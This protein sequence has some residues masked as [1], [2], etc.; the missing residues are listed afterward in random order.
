MNQIQLENEL[1]LLEIEPEHG[2]LVRLRDKMGNLELITEPRLAENFRLLLPVPGMHANYILGTEQELTSAE[3]T[4]QGIRL[5]W[6]GPL[7]NERG[8]FDLDVTIWIE[9]ID[10]EVRVRCEVQNHTKHPIAEVWYGL[11]GGMTGL[12]SAGQAK[13]TK[14]LLPSSA[15]QWTAE[16]FREFGIG[17]P[18]NPGL[19]LHG[20]EYTWWY[21][22]QMP[23]PWVSFYH[24]ELNRGVYFANH[25]REIRSKIFRMA[26]S[27]GTAERRADGDWPRP[28]E[29]NGEPLGVTMNWTHFPYTK[30]GETFVGPTLVLRCHDGGWQ[31]SAAIYRQ[32]FDQTWGAVDSRKDWLRG[33]TAFL[34]TM[35]MLP[36]DNINLTFREIPAWARTAAD[37]GITSVMI[38]GWQVGGHDRGYPQ[39][40]PDP[41]LGTYE[42][43]AAGIRACHDM[44]LR[45]YFFA[46]VQ[47]VDIS[48]DWYRKELHKY[49]TQDPFGCPFFVVGW[50]MGT[51]GARKGLTRTPL[52]ELNPAHPEVRKILVGYF[53]KLAEIGADG[54]HLDKNFIHPLDFNPRLPLAPDRAMPEGMLRC[55]EEILTSCREVKPDF[56]LSYENNWD[57]LFRYSDVFWW[58]M[59]PS[60]LKVAFPQ[61]TST[62]SVA[63]PYSFNIVNLLALGGNNI[64]V[65][66][67]NY[68][69][70]MDYPPM[71]EVCR[72]IGEV[73]RIR[74]ELH[75]YVSRGRWVDSHEKL[76]ASREP[77]LQMSGSFPGSKHAGWTVFANELNGKRAIV[78]A[79]LGGEPLD[80][81]DLG[82]VDNSTGACRVYQPFEPVRQARF[83]VTLRLLPE[84]VAFVVES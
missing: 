12:G 31:E 26:L 70:G 43:L 80:V 61:W 38:S 49:E 81:N 17:S 84:R 78:L 34:D 55:I 74:R 39:Y 36:E 46:N 83:P 24:E 45:V 9:L 63:Q 29:L 27:P 10:Q 40:E 77:T 68:Q 47:S 75:E 42:E 52:Y 30:P 28:E 8:A 64:M 18:P 20:P 33:E 71:K 15:T 2:A 59:G 65:G 1:Y 58:A 25:D 23:M 3:K 11:V 21:P 82:F 76:F 44:G 4:A 14:C 41:R 50:G 57:Q 60:P 32:W 73:T 56:C 35:F 54:I 7:R 51:V 48:T 53:R 19:G 5:S 22:G 67:A 69:R 6:A 37:H 79:N 16:P 72:Y 62:N 66:P 13:A